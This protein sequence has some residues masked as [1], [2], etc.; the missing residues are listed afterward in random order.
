MLKDYSEPRGTEIHSL[1][2]FSRANWFFS[3]LEQMFGYVAG[4]FT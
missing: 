4:I 3:L 2:K 1:L